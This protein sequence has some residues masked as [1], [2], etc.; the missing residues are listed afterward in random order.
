LIS[1]FAVSRKISEEEPEVFFR[2][3]ASDY[4]TFLAT[5]Q[6]DRRFRDG[7]TPRS[8]YIEPHRENL[9]GVPA[10]MSSSFGTNAAVLTSDGFFIFARRS[11]VVGSRPNVWSSSANEALSRTLDD[12]GRS[13]P[14][15]YDVMRR[16]ISE[17]LAIQS[18]EY[19]LEMLTI[20][21]DTELHQWGAYWLAVLRELTG[22]EV[23]ERRTRGAADKWEHTA[24]RL[25]PADPESV[26][27]FVLSMSFTGQMAPHTPSLFYFALVRRFGRHTVE[28][29]LKRVLRHRTWGKADR[30]AGGAGS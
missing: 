10:F 22:D 16:G 6:L 24:L 29:A 21:I 28:H 25:V 7:A 15:L 18:D 9:L 3:Q 14:N 13:A 1:S 8:R 11:G 12:R 20:T 5:Q 26:L 2:L 30:P 17:E 19:A 23:L 4:A 27:E